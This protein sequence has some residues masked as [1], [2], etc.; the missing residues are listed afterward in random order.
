[1]DAECP[2][3]DLVALLEFLYRLG[4]GYLASG[5]QTAVVELY[6]R[7]VAAVSGMCSVRVAVFSMVT[8]LASFWLLVP[9]VLGLLSVKRLLTDP[10]GLDGLITVVFAFMSI[11][12]GTLVGESI[13]QWL[14]E[15]FGW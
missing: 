15:R 12:L 13:Y 10:A 1:M 14:A 6:L 2:R 4:Q 5:E 3:A 8:Y 7:R 9:G 11:A